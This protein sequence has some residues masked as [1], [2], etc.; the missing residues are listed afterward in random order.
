MWAI[1]NEIRTFFKKVKE[2]IKEDK[3][4]EVSLFTLELVKKINDMIYKEE[5]ILFPM[6]LETLSHEEWVEVKQGERDIGY[7]WVRPRRGWPTQADK[8]KGKLEKEM[9]EGGKQLP[10]DTGMLSLEQLNLMLTH[11]PVDLTY[12]DEHDQVL[13]YSGGKDRIFPRSPGVIG[14]K[15]QKCHPSKSVKMV[16]KIVKEFKSGNRDI[17]EFWFNMEERFVHI[18]YYAVRDDKGKYK[19]VLEFSQDVTHIRHLEF[20]KRL[21]DW[22]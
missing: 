20:E 17:A 16:N 5:H 18:R 8:L 15:V 10:L 14:R 6:C 3:V 21:L 7:A 22:E 12:V 11:M 4:T 1:H 2:L 13:Y 19:G 9:K